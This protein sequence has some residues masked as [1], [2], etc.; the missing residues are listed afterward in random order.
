MGHGSGHSSHNGVVCVIGV[1]TDKAL[2]IK[3][4]SNFCKGCAQ[5]NEL[6]QFAFQYTRWKVTHI[7]SLIH[8]NSAGSMERKGAVRIFAGSQSDRYLRYTKYLKNGESQCSV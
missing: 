4:L 7:C 2:H 6:Q 5:W 1:A 8:D 3:V